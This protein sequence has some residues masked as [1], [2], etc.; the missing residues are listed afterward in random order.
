[1]PLVSRIG[2]A[3]TT[4]TEG[5][6]RTARWAAGGL[7]GAVAGGAR[8]ARA[9]I[10]GSGGEPARAPGGEGA[11]SQP[12]PAEGDARESLWARSGG[13]GIAHGVRSPH[14]TAAVCTAIALLL[15]IWIG[16]TVHV[17]TNN[18]EAAGIGVLISWPAAFAALALI[19]VPFA[20]GVA[21]YRRGRGGNAREETNGG[22][23]APASS[24]FL[25]GPPVR[26]VTG[27]RESGG[28]EAS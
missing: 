19:C 27:S 17:W 24:A 28:E 14:R 21:L 22:P 9:A 26:T 10:T 13:A 6:S 23:S 15:A 20:G 4:A 5:T 7:A 12:K 1:M 25:A 3:W 2:R 11:A 8:K 18:G 16:W